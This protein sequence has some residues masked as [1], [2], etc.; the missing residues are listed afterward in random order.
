MS[1]D[2]FPQNSPLLDTK[3]IDIQSPTNGLPVSYILLPLIPS[4]FLSSNLIPPSSPSNG[5]P[6]STLQQSPSQNTQQYNSPQPY[7]DSNAV[8]LPNTDDNSI[9][10]ILAL[11]LIVLS[12]LALAGY[13]GFNY[14][15][16]KMT[17]KMKA[18]IMQSAP[19]ATSIDAKDNA[20]QNQAK[21][22]PE[23]YIPPT[24]VKIQDQSKDVVPPAQDQP[25]P[26]AVDSISPKVDEPNPSSAPLITPLD[27]QNS[28]EN[29]PIKR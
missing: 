15:N 5:I 13:F 26:V 14:V 25:K 29:F 8:L 20:V 2:E 1:N 16:G 28:V 18:S 11:P 21:S 17:G 23:N 7:I 22:V 10:K 4:N 27:N 3:K 12:I 6:Y 24:A 19:A 9:L